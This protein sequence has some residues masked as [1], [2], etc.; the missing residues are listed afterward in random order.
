MHKYVVEFIGT[1]FLMF[2]VGAVVFERSAEGF[3]PIAIGLVLTA[4]VFAGG[5]IS[6]THYNPAVTISF[7]LRGRVRSQDILPY[8]LSQVAGASAAAILVIFLFDTPHGEFLQLDIIRAFVSEVVFTFAL[9]FVILNVATSAG[10]AGNSYYGLAIGFVVAGG[11]FCVGEISGAV[12]NPAVAIGITTLG[13]TSISDMWIYFLSN[14]TGG[15]L[16][17][18]VFK[19]TDLNNI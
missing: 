4:M 7:W 6:G 15:V 12:F 16:A 19:K 13:I 1:F 18:V 2:T 14:I 3:A 8:I 9:V 10:T 11:I 5:H 17:T